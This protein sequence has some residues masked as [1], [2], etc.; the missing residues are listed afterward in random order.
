M[1][2]SGAPRPFPGD[3]APDAADAEFWAACRDG[4]YL[5]MRCGTCGHAVWPAGACPR[6]GAAPMA[7]TDASGRGALVTW[8]VV[9]Q[10]YAT[11][12]AGAPPNVALVELDEGPLVH[13]TVLGAERLE[14]GMRLEVAFEEIAPDVVLPVFRPARDRPRGSLS[15]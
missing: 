9:H 15:G 5:V 2:G 6:H 7:W 11:S 14:I 13:A 12:F 10:R 1:S 8:T 4:R 3:V